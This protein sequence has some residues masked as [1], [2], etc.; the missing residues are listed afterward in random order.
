M[1]FPLFRYKII[2]M[3]GCAE[4]DIHCPTNLNYYYKKVKFP[5]TA[6]TAQQDIA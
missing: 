2:Q 6:Q 4:F 5:K 1:T 3:L